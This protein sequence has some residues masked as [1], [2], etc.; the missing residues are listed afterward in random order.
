MSSP[1][2][3]VDSIRHLHSAPGISTPS[4]VFDQHPSYAVI[5]LHSRV[6]AVRLAVHLLNG[7]SPEEMPARWREAD[8]LGPPGPATEYGHCRIALARRPVPPR[9]SAEEAWLRFHETLAHQHSIGVDHI[10]K[11]NGKGEKGDMMKILEF[12][13]QAFAGTPIV[14]IMMKRTPR[15]FATVVR[16]FQEPAACK[17]PCAVS[18]FK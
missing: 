5:T 9:G 1:V 2:K 12:T 15:A 3:L 16:C 17:T 11:K 4:A 13:L 6:D 18:G 7:G 10:Q 14:G 8:F